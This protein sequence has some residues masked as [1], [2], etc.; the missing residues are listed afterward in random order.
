MWI[1]TLELRLK[2]TL[3]LQND[4]KNNVITRK[5]NIICFF[6]CV[7][8]FKLLY[9]YIYNIFYVYIFLLYYIYFY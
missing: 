1:S 6:E 7:S 9:M 5:I 4:E 8:K 3:E 2:K